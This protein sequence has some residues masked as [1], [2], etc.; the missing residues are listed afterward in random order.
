M[1]GTHYSEILACIFTVQ[2]KSVYSSEIF[3]PIDRIKR[4]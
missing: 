1:E 4:L 3:V 2:M